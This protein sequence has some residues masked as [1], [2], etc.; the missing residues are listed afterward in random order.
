MAF[1]ITWENKFLKL[2]TYSNVYLLYQSLSFRNVQ[3]LE[4]GVTPMEICSKYYKIHSEVYEWFNVQFDYFGR[5]TTEK[6]T[7]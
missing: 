2:S 1:G 3:A 7:E 5:T 6:Q 4:E